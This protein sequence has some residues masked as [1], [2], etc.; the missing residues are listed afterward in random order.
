MLIA[1]VDAGPLYAAADADDDDH[2]SCL[3]VLQR[4]DL[5]L[6][7]PALVVAEATYLV[8][9][10][11]GARIEA[12]FLGGLTAVEVEAPTEGDWPV[13]AALVEQ[14]RDFP[15][16]GTDASVAVLADRL[17]TNL[18]VTLDRR[19]FSAI[20]STRQRPYHLLPE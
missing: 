13:I 15:L 9:R 5:E 3:S 19:H 10:R 2:A 18:I 12:A 20:R 11:L 7:V 1:I 8:G 17:D 16:G 14:Y 4:P 6:V